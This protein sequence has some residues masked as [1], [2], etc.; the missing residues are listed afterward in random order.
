[1]VSVSGGDVAVVL[2]IRESGNVEGCRGVPCSAGSDLDVTVNEIAFDYDVEQV[3]QDILSVV[4]L[5]IH[6][7]DV[8][9]LGVDGVFAVK[10]D[11][12]GVSDGA[13]S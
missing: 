3:Q 13:K 6:L 4:E 10:R 2:G 5:G 9:A 11:E 8:V 1:M 7:H 12:V